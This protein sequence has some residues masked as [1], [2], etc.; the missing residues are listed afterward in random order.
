MTM[1]RKWHIAWARRIDRE[2]DELEAWVQAQ[3]WE[4]MTRADYEFTRGRYV[5]R[6]DRIQAEIWQWEQVP[7]S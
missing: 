4:Q 3:R 5:E 2:L 6:A 7:V 1:P